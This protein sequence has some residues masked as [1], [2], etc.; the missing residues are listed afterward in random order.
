MLQFY[1]NPVSANARRVWVTLLEKNLPFEPVLVKLD[2]DHLQEDFTALNPLQRVPVLVDGDL[3]IIESLAILD[4]LEAQYP[5]PAL[6]PTDPAAIAT[7]RMVELT[8]VNDL[9]PL[10]IPLT[11]KFVGLSVEEHKLNAARQRILQIFQFYDSLLTGRSY[12]VQE[13]LTLA[14]IVAGTLVPSLGHMDFTLED[15]PHL[16]NWAQRLGQRA[17]WQQTELQ[18]EQIEAALPNIRKILEQRL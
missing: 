13:Q 11:G 4:Y 12:F 17:S 6:M 16:H 1:Y 18:P 15:Y 7:V 2:G 14:D 8:A 9:Q 5:K 3:K 10:T